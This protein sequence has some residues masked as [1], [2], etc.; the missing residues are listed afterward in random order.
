VIRCIMQAGGSSERVC[1]TG[2]LRM[3]CCTCID[4]VCTAGPHPIPHPNVAF[5]VVH[6]HVKIQAQNTELVVYR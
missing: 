1:E 6:W 5:A 3:P 2:E 4:K